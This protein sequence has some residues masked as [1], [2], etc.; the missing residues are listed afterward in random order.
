M[1]LLKVHSVDIMI[2]SVP[3]IIVMSHWGMSMSEVASP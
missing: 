3:M 1:D 2:M